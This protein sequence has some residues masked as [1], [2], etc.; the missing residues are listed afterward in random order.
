MTRAALSIGGS[1]KARVPEPA[2]GSGEAEQ[3]APLSKALAAL[4]A[5]RGA[6]GLSL[7]FICIERGR[8]VLSTNFDPRTL[9]PN[10]DALP[11][12]S[13]RGPAGS[14]LRVDAR[15]D[16]RRLLADAAEIGVELEVCVNDE[17]VEAS[18]LLQEIGRS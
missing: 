18:K 14:A 4:V 1:K 5:A 12:V 17:P 8:F 3:D 6:E 13:V 11:R 15:C 16:L 9:S 10:E 7:R 2:T